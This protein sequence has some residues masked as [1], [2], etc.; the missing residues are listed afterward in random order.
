MIAEIQCL[1]TPPGT[2]D[3]PYAHIEA[4]IS[5]LA[6]TG[7]RYEVGALGTPLDGPD[8]AVGAALRA[9][10]EA[11]LAVGAHSAVAI[12]KV[13]SASGEGPTM[14]GLVAGHR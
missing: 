3:S 7:L 6:D 14:D 2:A 9:A 13:A 5:A 12:I 1:P 8:E 10:H 11:V 4:A